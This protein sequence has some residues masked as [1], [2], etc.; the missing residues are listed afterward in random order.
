MAFLADDTPIWHEMFKKATGQDFVMYSL[1]E[2]LDMHRFISDEDWKHFYMGD[3][4]THS[5]Y[6]DL[7]KKEYGIS[8]TDNRRWKLTDDIREM[9]RLVRSVVAEDKAKRSAST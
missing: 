3:E 1:L 8:S 4:G 5:M 6:V 9:F 2:Q 7:V